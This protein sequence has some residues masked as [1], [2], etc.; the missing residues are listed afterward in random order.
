MATTP[1]QDA[2]PSESPRDL[3]FNAGKIDE[4]VNSLAMQYIDRFGQA[5]YTIEGI[6]ALAK[7]VINQLGWIPSGTFQDGATLVNPN[8]T[9]KDNLSGEYYRWD[10]A[11]PKK[12]VAGSTPDNSGGIG[13]SAWVSVGDG[14]LRTMLAS[15]SEGQGDSLVCVKQ[16]GPGSIPRTQHE[17]NAEIPSLKDYGA[18]CDGVTDDR[19]AYNALVSQY[20]TGEF[21]VP[22][23]TMIGTRKIPAGKFSIASRQFANIGTSGK[24]QNPTFSMNAL[25]WNLTTGWVYNASPDRISHLVAGASSASTTIQMKGLTT[26][27]V[28]ISINV[29]ADGI[30]NIKFGGS[31]LFQSEVVWQESG[32]SNPGFWLSAVTSPN[33]SSTEQI[34]PVSTT[35]WLFTYRTNLTVDGTNTSGDVS[36]EISTASG[37][38]FRGE[39]SKLQVIEISSSLESTFGSIPAGSTNVRDIYG[40]KISQDG[41]Y[42]VL[43]YG[44]D[45]TLQIVNGD[46]GTASEGAHN[47]AFGP[48]VGAT[49]I[50]GDENAMFGAMSSQWMTGSGNTSLGYSP[51]KFALKAME[52]TAVGYKSSISSAYVVG[53]TTV[54]FRSSFFN[55][56]G[57]YVTAIGHKA[58]ER[59]I[60]GKYG[61]HIGTSSGFNA[62]GDYSTS[63]GYQ[64][65]SYV[66]GGPALNYTGTTSVGASSSTFG[67]FNTT[68]GYGSNA[69]FYNSLTGT[70]TAYTSATAIGY[71]AKAQQNGVAVGS[72]SQAIGTFG[73][74]VGESS[75]AN[76]SSGISIGQQAGTLSNGSNNTF[77]GNGAGKYSSA[78]T[79]ENT[80]CLGAASVCTGSNQVQLG[81]AGT[82][83]YAYANLQLR[84]DARDKA[85]VVES[86]LGIDFIL[87][88]KPK[89]GYYDFRESYTEWVNTEVTD[90]ETGEITL[91]SELIHHEKDGS[92][93]QEQ[94][95]HWFIAQEVE[96]LCKSLGVEFGGIRHNKTGDERGDVYSLSYEQ[97]VPPV[98][99]S[100]Q[101]CWSRMDGLEKRIAELEGRNN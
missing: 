45:Q 18:A 62:G 80:S 72:N 32:V 101:D 53:A 60:S 100:L 20:P 13:V 8:Q 67:N 28:R 31:N 52:C 85:D 44:D 98:V 63:V 39:V 11:L 3:K 79:F 96:D 37:G 57:N 16:P 68:L 34:K 4:F 2:V 94:L 48:R 42:N 88:L 95:T 26:Y 70:I 29:V 76:G 82:T 58:N 81:G 99:K 75:V 25:G 46:G 47:I 49:L 87:G 71:L 92:R 19:A 12:V 66:G 89:Q 27:L 38:T 24:V 15:S 21:Y 14:A 5:H 50:N 23:P 54:G 22:S 40:P 6:N 97:F 9:L 59:N 36:L 83:P 69:G 64:S 84:S 93:K 77:I 51:L 86:E 43:G 65:G 73:I 7:Q 35:E 61:T 55:T 91:K 1:T 30:L 33:G 78:N 90:K 56:L 17:K 74:A 41:G 10:G